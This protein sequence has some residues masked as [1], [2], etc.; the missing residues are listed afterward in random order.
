M[1][2]RIKF[3]LPISLGIIVL[4]IEAIVLFFLGTRLLGRFSAEMDRRLQDAI[5][6][7]GLLV[8]QGALSTDAF[9]QR[10]TLENLVGPALDDALIVTASG[11]VLVALDPTAIGQSWN[12]LTPGSTER[13]KRAAA[14]GFTERITEGTNTFLIR[15]APVNVAAGQAPALFD[16][17]R[18]RTT[19]S[20]G[21]LAALRRFII[22]GSLAAFLVT[23]IALLIA[24]HLLVTRRLQVVGEAVRQVTEGRYETRMP[25]G[26][27]RDEITFL[28]SAFNT[29]TDRLQEAFARLQS[30]TREAEAAEQKYRL[31]VENAAEAI[32]VAQDGQLVFANPE[33]CKLL[34]CTP[35]EALASPITR[36]VHPDDQALIAERHAQ[37]LRGEAPPNR[38]QFRLLTCDGRLLRVELS[39]VRIEWKGAPASLN[40]ITDIT[41]RHRAEQELK[42]VSAFRQ[43][44]LERINEGLCLCHEVVEE[45]FVRFTMWNPRMTEIT[46]YTLEEINTRGWYQSLYPDPAVRARAVERMARMRTGDNLYDE[47]W[48]IVRSDGAQR[49]LAISTS[50]IETADGSLHVLGLMR[51]VTERRRAEEAIRLSQTQLLASLENTPNVAIQWYD[52]AGKVLYWNPA[53]EKLY[54]WKSSEALGKT[55]DQLIHTPEETADFLN[56]LAKIKQNGQPIAPYEAPVRR[57]DGSRGWVLATTFSIPLGG[58]RPG[59]VCMDMD[60]TDRKQAEHDREQLQ[61]QLIQAQKMESVGRL[62]GGVA[63]DFNNMLQAIIGN[64]D[65][66]L[67]LAPT[68]SSIRECLAEINNSARRSAELTRQL[69]AFARKQ[70]VTPKVVNLNELIAELLVM[71]RRLLGEHVELDYRA[72]ADLWHTQIDPSQV[73]QVLTNLCVN[74]RDAIS[75]S[76]RISIETANIRLDESHATLNFGNSPG[77]YVVLR[78]SDTGAGMD[79]ATRAQ[80]FEPFFTTKAVGKGTGLGLATVFGIVKQN[81]GLIQVDSEPGQGTTFSIYLPRSLEGPAPAEPTEAVAKTTGRETILLVEDEPQVLSLGRR[82]LARSGYHVLGAA[83]PEIA[84][85]LAAQHGTGIQL[86]ITDVIMPG[87]NGRL[88]RDRLRQEHPT[89]KCL[90][91]SGYTADVVGQHGILEDGIDFV[92]KP[93]T[94]ESFCAK[95]R[96]ILDS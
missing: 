86:L 29:M 38:Y 71:L 58:G 1:T 80:I 65:L 90:F 4:T 55:L 75:G 31:L 11:T 66:A 43:V 70:S 40:F 21:E 2:S 56:L 57:A 32:F 88:L 91:M 59:Y 6:K 9:G 39:V 82:I 7:P 54:G 17:V 46:G 16:Y 64:A 62:A 5:A 13:L 89:L 12:R 61:A 69:L 93:F 24:A 63:H 15:V 72:G 27:W 47:Q 34:G 30:A 37:R 53:S 83:N 68:D 77:D 19:E 48:E 85:E 3:G 67:A 45:P 42:H 8:A 20:E 49:T 52:E 60:I 81:D 26:A 50:L 84:L 79:A 10:D 14:G 95:V 35:E 73:D 96:E 76:G 92:Q 23:T 33:C 78:V 74:A 28:S 44:L 51:D 36:F 22:G 87:M 41:E 94:I 18:L 25:E